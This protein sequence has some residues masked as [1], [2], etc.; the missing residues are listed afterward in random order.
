MYAK[1]TKIGQKKMEK[2]PYVM[3]Q[4]YCHMTQTWL[5]LVVSINTK[6]SLKEWF[7]D[8]SAVVDG[9]GKIG[10]EEFGLDFVRRSTR[11]GTDKCD[12]F[13]AE[14][15]EAEFVRSCES[16]GLQAVKVKRLGNHVPK[17][18]KYAGKN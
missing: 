1:M 12:D 14:V 18:F 8:G 11:P 16:Q 2:I 7:Y 9:L 3:R 15:M 10:S 13:L 5:P 4:E 6:P 17:G